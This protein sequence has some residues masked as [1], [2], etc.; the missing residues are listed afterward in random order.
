MDDEMSREYR[1]LRLDQAMCA[2]LR[3][4]IR[5]PID[6]SGPP[7]GV[8]GFCRRLYLAYYFFEADPDL[9]HAS[10]AVNEADIMIINHFVSA[11]D[12]EWA[13]DVLHQTRQVLYEL[14]TGKEAVRLAAAEDVERLVGEMTLDPDGAPPP[15]ESEVLEEDEEPKPEGEK[16]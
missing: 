5:P 16:L 15:E 1:Q 3:E 14:T 11:E 8:E 9:D 13:K 6:R 4:I 2:G 7:D 10:F 12:G